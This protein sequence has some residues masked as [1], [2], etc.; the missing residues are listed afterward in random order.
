M[1]RKDE[2][3]I[4]DQQRQTIINREDKQQGDCIAQGAIGLA[5]TFIQIIPEHFMET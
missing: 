5:K 3:G 4:W 1:W 2:V